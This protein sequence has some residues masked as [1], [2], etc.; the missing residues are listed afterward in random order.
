M[1]KALLPMLA[2]LLICGTATGA[3]IATTAH[4]DQTGRK[5]V[6]V[7]MA[8]NQAAP[9]A[10]NLP[11]PPP[12]MD[13]RMMRG[14]RRGQ[15]CENMYAGKAGEMAFLEAKLQLTAAQQPLFARWKDLSLDLAKRHEGDC[16]GRVE[17]MRAGGQRPDMMQRL[18][19]EEDMLKTRLADIQAER[20]SLNALY[21]SLT[22][23][24]KQE[25]A[26]AAGPAMGDRMH[27]AMGMMGHGPEMGRRFGRGPDGGMPMPPPPPGP[28][29]Q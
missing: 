15:M 1:R 10:A 13:R 4:A 14:Q 18:D 16:N 27:M 6:M 7:M 2:S 26:R 28:P 22:A 23:T 12:P 29:P 20:P 21:A 3:L 8:Q 11:G 5:P 25:F 19:R 17:K 24:Q 9:D